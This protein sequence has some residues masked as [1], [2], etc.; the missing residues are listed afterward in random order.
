MD[1]INSLQALA[2]IIPLHLVNTGHL[3]TVHQTGGSNDIRFFFFEED[4]TLDKKIWRFIPL[5]SKPGEM[6]LHG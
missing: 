4:G 1:G 2:N 5:I 3:G 6:F